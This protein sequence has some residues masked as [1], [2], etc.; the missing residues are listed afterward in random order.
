MCRV[1]QTA[2]QEQSSV[3]WAFHT[4][5]I[6]NNIPNAISITELQKLH[7]QAAPGTTMLE[8]TELTETANEAIKKLQEIKDQLS[9]CAPV[10][11]DAHRW[12]S[13]DK[14]QRSIAQAI[15][16]LKKSISV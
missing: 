1:A 9:N 12:E 13:I 5:Q 10:N 14:S 11:I 3:R 6:M 4:P 8:P 16:H 2:L 7:S 15:R